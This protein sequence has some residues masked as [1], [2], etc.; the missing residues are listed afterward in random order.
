M[1]IEKFTANFI[2]IS[3]TYD[4]K[5][6][7]EIWHNDAVLEGPSVGRKFIGHTR[8]KDYFESY[9]IGYKTQTRLV[10]LGIINENED[11]IEFEFTGDF[12]KREIGGTFEFIFKNGK[13]EKAKED[14]IH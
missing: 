13:I 14:L 5:N 8:I 7:L 3:N 10:K 6:Y 12:P 9:F 11:Q 4:T 2:A 1:E